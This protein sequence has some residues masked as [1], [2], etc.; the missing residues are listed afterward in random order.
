[1]RTSCWNKNGI[2][3]LLYDGVR[4]DAVNVLQFIQHRRRQVCRLRMD[5]ISIHL[6]LEIR[7]YELADRSGILAAEYVPYGRPYSRVFVGGCVDHDVDGICEIHVE[8]RG[9]TVIVVLRRAVGIVH[10]WA[11]LGTLD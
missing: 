11:Y 8:P 6:I 4:Y 2:A 9:A 7:S 1:M 5:W 3:R 10:F